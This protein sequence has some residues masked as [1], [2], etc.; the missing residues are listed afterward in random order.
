[1]KYWIIFLIRSLL[2][3]EKQQ[4]NKAVK[5]KNANTR[6]LKKSRIKQLCI[7]KFF[8]LCIICVFIFTLSC[9]VQLYG[10]WGGNIWRT[11]VG[12]TITREHTS[13]YMQ[14]I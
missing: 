8:I 3:I 2:Y 1:M 14:Y 7:S 4:R 11:T 5:D 6:E 9:F 12:T 10:I 13:T